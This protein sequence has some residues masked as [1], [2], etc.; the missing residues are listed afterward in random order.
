MYADLTDDEISQLIEKETILY[1]NY[2]D[3][4]Q[5]LVPIIEA[6]T[7]EF[8]KYVY[9]ELRSLFT[10]LARARTSKST[11]D[12]KLKHITG[13]ERHLNRMIRDL[14][15]DLCGLIA[16][17]SIE[18]MYSNADAIM[19][20]GE[21][22]EFYHQVFSKEREARNAFLDAKEL[23][24]KGCLTDQEEFLLFKSYEKAYILYGDLEQLLIDKETDILDKAVYLHN[25]GEKAAKKWSIR[26]IV[27][28][29]ICSIAF[30]LL[31]LIIEL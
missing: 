10:H 28:T 19:L 23:D 27:I 31:G 9:V 17:T 30:F 16:E 7:T 18:I 21:K 11:Y 5:E 13:A 20:I 24:T 1:H 2:S 26:G 6:R 22:G 4:V 25:R 14:Y 12:E 8:P 29:V 15:K 3:I